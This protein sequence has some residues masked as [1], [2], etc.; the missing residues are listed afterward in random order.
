MN[1][2]KIPFFGEFNRSSQSKDDR[3]N[4]PK[5]GIFTFFVRALSRTTSIGYSKKHGTINSK[6]YLLAS[7]ADRLRMHSNWI[8][9]AVAQKQ[10]E[11]WII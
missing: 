7:Q 6:R 11:Q 2:I 9:R 8:L 10:L 4:S 3:L 1:K 5:S